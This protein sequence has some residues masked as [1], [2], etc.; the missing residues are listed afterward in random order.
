MLHISVTMDTKWLAAMSAFVL[1][2]EVGPTRLHAHEVSGHI[3]FG[4][5]LKFK[6][7]KK[8]YLRGQTQYS[9]GHYLSIHV[10]NNI[11][12]V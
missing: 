3:S 11:T 5:F 1:V 10:Y 9:R 6:L 8:N 7:S 2:T 4:A 12:S